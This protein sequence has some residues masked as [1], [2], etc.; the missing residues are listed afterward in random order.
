MIRFW[1][2]IKERLMRYQD[3][4]ER[5]RRYH[6][7]FA[8]LDSGIADWIPTD[9]YIDDMYAFFQNCYHLKDWLKKD[10]AFNAPEDIEKFVTKTPCLALCADICNATKHLGLDP[11]KHPPRT[12]H[13]PKIGKREYKV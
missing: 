13:E 12:G 10:P 4:L 11:K 6:K 2:R 7:R 8:D 9:N 1:D 5:V 3:Q